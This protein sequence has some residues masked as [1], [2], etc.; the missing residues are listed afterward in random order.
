MVRIEFLVQTRWGGRVVTPGDSVGVEDR[1]AERLARN[2][3]AAIIGSKARVSIVV[4]ATGGGYYDLV[5]DGV[6]V[7]RVRGRLAAEA[8]ATELSAG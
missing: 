8:R 6:V 5:R 3:I 7:E 1:D 2:G 4:E